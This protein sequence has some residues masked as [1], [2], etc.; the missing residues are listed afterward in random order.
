VN[1]ENFKLVHCPFLLAMDVK[2]EINMHKWEYMIIERGITEEELNRLGAQGWELVLTP[3]GKLCFI[4]KRPIV[5]VS[6]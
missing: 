3:P 1:A 2:G 5:E 4:F 6:G